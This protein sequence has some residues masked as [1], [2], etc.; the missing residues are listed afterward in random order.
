M[1]ESQDTP[2]VL[3]VD[4]NEN[5]LKVLYS[6]LRQLDCKLVV[7]KSGLDA[8]EVAERTGPSV[9]LL[10]ILMPGIDGF[11]T[12][13]RLRANPKTGEAAIIFLSALNET[14]D[15]VRGFEAG[16]VDYVSKPFQAEEVLARVKTQLTLC[17]LR[18]DL[19]WRNQELVKLN[20]QKNHLLGMAA[21]DLRNPLGVITGYAKI[22]GRGMLGPLTQQ[23]TEVSQLIYSAGSRMLALLNDL[24]DISQIESGH[25][26]LSIREVNPRE[27]F[28]E[29]VKLNCYRAIAKQIELIEQ[30]VEPVP[31]SIRVDPGKMQQ[32]FENLL[33]NAVKFSH[34]NTTVTARM[35]AESEQLLVEV[36]DQGPGIPPDEVDRLFEPFSRTSVRA[37]AGEKSTGLGL[38]IVKRIVEGH[39]GKIEVDSRLGEGTTFTVWLPTG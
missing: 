11:E 9:I 12:C 15:K 19:V 16:G 25:L 2:V 24:L 26:Q 28:Q 32:V 29:S 38:A 30:I 31:E 18:Q 20:D 21:H 33:S 10:D 13:R 8:L 35:R 4:D 3:L 6:T 34:S 27:L 39:G 14:Q 5:N 17:Q 1:T 22:L 7:A 37:T 23:Q 36:A